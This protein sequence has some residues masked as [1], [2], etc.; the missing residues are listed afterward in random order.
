MEARNAEFLSIDPPSRSHGARRHPHMIATRWRMEG[1]RCRREDQIRVAS[2]CASRGVAGDHFTLT[3]ASVSSALTGHERP[4]S[5]HV[6][7]DTE[8]RGNR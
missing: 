8:T 5:D 3:A 1:R 6:L 2:S 7:A 4:R